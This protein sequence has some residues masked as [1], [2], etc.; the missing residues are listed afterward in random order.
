MYARKKFGIWNKP[1]KNMGKNLEVELY[2]INICNFQATHSWDIVIFGTQ[3]SR[4]KTFWSCQ[5][6]WV[7]LSS[8][9]SRMNK[10]VFSVRIKLELSR[11]RIQSCL[12]KTTKSRIDQSMLS[13]G[14]PPAPPR[15]PPPV[16]IRVTDASFFAIKTRKRDLFT[17]SD[18]CKC[19]W[20][21]HSHE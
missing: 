19:S 5:V 14:R 8:T 10:T 20:H 18:A 21:L 11:W 3:Q 16:L 15:Q 9:T 2:T 13:R 7:S 4:R 1:I 17:L 6:D 12:I